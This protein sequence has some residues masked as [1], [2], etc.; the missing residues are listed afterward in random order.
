MYQPPAF[1]ED[2]LE[3]QH[4]LI[5]AHPLG[6]LVSAGAEGPLASPVPFVLHE[7]EGP[8]GTLR[9]HL[10]RANP[11]LEVLGGADALV[12]F[13]VT[14]AYVTPSW[15]ASKREHGRVVPTWNYAQVQARG[16]ARLVHDPAWLGE[17]VAALTALQEGTRPAPWAVDDAP[18]RFIEAQLRGIVG[19]EIPIARIEGKVK[20][21]QNRPEADREGVAAGLEAEAPGSPMARLVRERARP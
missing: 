13:T 19:V 5:R 2:R 6:L 9:C 14:D 15:Y 11:H 7:G 17:H 20:A 3:A 21:S 10:A 16:T 4:A 18:P 12:V 1:R 8:L